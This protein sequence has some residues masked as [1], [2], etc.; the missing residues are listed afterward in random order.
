MDPI[1][2]KYKSCRERAKLRRKIRMLQLTIAILVTAF[3]GHLIY[4]WA[5]NKREVVAN[6]VPV[7]QTVYHQVPPAIYITNK[8]YNYKIYKV[9]PTP[10][11]EPEPTPSPIPE[12]QDNTGVVEN[13]LD[14]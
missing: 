2:I 3:I 8:Y 7:V 5:G 10:V 1:Q 13:S 4:D 9:E 12:Y 6:P 11:V 14:E